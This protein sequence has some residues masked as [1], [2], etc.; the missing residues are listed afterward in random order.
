MDTIKK[1]KLVLLF[2][3]F[4]ACVPL[5]ADA[6]PAWHQGNIREF[7]SHDYHTW[8][9]GYWHHGYYGPRFGWWW[10]VAGAWYFYPQPV[11]PYP[12]PYTPPVVIIQPSAPPVHVPQPQPQPQFWYYCESATGYYPYV[13][14]CPE[15][16]KKVPATPPTAVAPT[17]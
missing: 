6:H 14:S 10:V 16:W 7:Y 3:A 11:Y 1:Y 5:Y 2:T 17:K 4:V 15:E 9:S 13:S 12:D 8:Q